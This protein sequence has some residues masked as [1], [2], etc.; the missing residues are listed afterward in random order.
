MDKK[1]A[2]ALIAGILA[3]SSGGYMLG[4]QS[5]QTAIS[6]DPAFTPD[7]RLESVRVFP[8][9]NSCGYGLEVAGSIYASP[10]A[11]EAL[12][13]ARRS[14]D[15]DCAR[16]EAYLGIARQWL[17]GRREG[18]AIGTLQTVSLFPAPSEPG[19]WGLEVV[20]ELGRES[21]PAP[22]LP[23][24]LLQVLADFYTR[25]PDGGSS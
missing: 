13:Q 6:A 11:T 23:P 17:A 4:G 14:G 2:L 18:G 21:G 12:R 7:F 9:E 19:G 3:G 20:D 22:T 16:L 10:T 5:V 24:Q 8:A 25:A 15:P 1:Y